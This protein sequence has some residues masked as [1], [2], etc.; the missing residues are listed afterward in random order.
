M[1]I[2]T[3]CSVSD[4]SAASFPRRLRSCFIA[5]SRRLRPL[6]ITEMSGPKNLPSVPP[7]SFRPVLGVLKHAPPIV[8]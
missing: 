6:S 8:A 4:R 1:V 7:E 5:A 3:D 2:C